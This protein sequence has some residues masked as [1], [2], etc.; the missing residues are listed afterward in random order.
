[1]GF[2]PWLLGVE[3]NKGKEREQVRMAWTRGRKRGS[4]PGHR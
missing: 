2:F 4:G 3:E 1:M